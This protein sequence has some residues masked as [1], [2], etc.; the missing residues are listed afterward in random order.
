HLSS[1]ERKKLK[2][3]SLL[4]SLGEAIL[5]TEQSELIKRTLGDH[6]FSRF[7]ELK[8][9]EWEDYRIQVTKYELDKFLPIL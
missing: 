2:I 8:K 4:D 6:I 7:I 1:E 3:E 9:K 5:I